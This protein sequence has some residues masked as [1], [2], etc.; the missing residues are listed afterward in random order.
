MIVLR[1][2]DVLTLE[3]LPEEIRDA[4]PPR[5]PSPAGAKADDRGEGLGYHDAVREAK[6]AI[7]RRALDNS[8]NVQTRAAKLLG[9]TQPYMERLM[10]NLDVKK[11][12]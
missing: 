2:A 5:A 9:L 8:D 12:P 10:K 1:T 7:L 6:R 3:D 4:R 11:N